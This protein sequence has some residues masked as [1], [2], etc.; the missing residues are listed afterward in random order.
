MSRDSKPLKVNE[1]GQYNRVPED[2]KIDQQQAELPLV[3]CHNCGRKFRS[4]RIATHQNICEK[5][6]DG[7]SRRGVYTKS[8]S[9]NTSPLPSPT[10]HLSHSQKAI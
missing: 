10:K 1:S 8:N 9:A 2:L 3:E 5:V 6:K 7:A 4:D